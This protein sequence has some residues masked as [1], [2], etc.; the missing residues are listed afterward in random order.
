MLFYN[1]CKNPIDKS[2]LTDDIKIK[3]K[4]KETLNIL[5]SIYI[6][7]NKGMCVEQHRSPIQIDDMKSEC[8]VYA[9]AK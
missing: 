8:A 6:N 7:L 1:A 3:L 2:N 4:A 5:A 9:F